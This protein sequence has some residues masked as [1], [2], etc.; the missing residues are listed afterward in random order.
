MARAAVTATDIDAVAAAMLPLAAHANEV[1]FDWVPFSENPPVT[2]TGSGSITLDFSSWALTGTSN[3]PNFGPYY[4]SGSAITATITAFSYTAADGQTADLADLSTTV[5]GKPPQQTATVWNTSGLDT[6]AAGAQSPSPP[7]AGYYLVTQFSASGHTADG[8]P[9]MIANNSGTAG[10]AYQNGIPNGD[11]TFNADG[12][13][14]ATEDGGYWEVAPVSAGR[15]ATAAERV[16]ATGLDRAVPEERNERFPVAGDVTT[17][18]RSSSVAEHAQASSSAT[19][20]TAG[21]SSCRR[22]FMELSG[23]RTA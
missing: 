9:F 18:S 23:R 19:E 22:T 6:P 7:T 15:T 8:T 17:L 1:T 12:S 14:P 16:G 3:P 20:S 10:A 5:I 2:S 21:N 13:V 11:V 4:S